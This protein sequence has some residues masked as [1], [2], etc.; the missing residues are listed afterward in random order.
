MAMAPVV[1]ELQSPVVGDATGA[2]FDDNFV[3][4][5]AWDLDS[6]VSDAETADADIRW[7]YIVGDFAGLAAPPLSRYSLNNVDPQ[8]D[9]SAAEAIE[10]PA[11]LR[12]D[13]QVLGGEV[14]DDTNARTV[15]IR[16]RILSPIGGPNDDPVTLGIVASE[17]V[18]LFASDGSTVTWATT[19]IFT[20]NNGPDRF[21]GGV[22]VEETL[23]GS[24]WTTTDFVYSDFDPTQPGNT[25]YAQ[26]ATT[27]ACITVAAAG[28]NIGSLDSPADRFS[29]ADLM[30]YR[31]RMEMSTTAVAG[32]TPLISMTYNS[33]NNEFG[34]EIIV[35]DNVGSAN[36]P[37]NGTTGRG[38]FQFWIT[39]PGLEVAAWRSQVD[40]AY[41][42]ANSAA[43]NFKLVLRL[44]DVA[45]VVNGANRVGTV[46][47]KT[48]ELGR[49]PLSQLIAGETNVYT[50][51]LVA[52]DGATGFE[53]TNI[54]GIDQWAVTFAS[55]V[56]TITADQTPTVGVALS[57]FRPGNG[58]GSAGTPAG[59]PDDYPV[60]WD[61][62]N[63]LLHIAYSIAATNAASAAD[64][65]EVMRLG[66]DTPT[67]EIITNHFVSILG[68]G[69][70]LMPT[71]T[72]AT[73]HAF[74]FTHSLTAAV[75][76]NAGTIRPLLDFADRN[77]GGEFGTD[78]TVT[79]T[80]SFA[81]SEVTVGDV[82]P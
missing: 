22:S 74:H 36:M 34:G 50:G 7:S 28:D 23:D 17:T 13:N 16:D 38:E 44:L 46:C 77:A 19:I 52:A 56:A 37:T 10:P 43:L 18:T 47:W 58:D 21:S 2:T 67:Q 25:T 68:I 57:T 3:F 45:A 31:G 29:I 4:P 49:V 60:A 26:N 1:Q 41:A 55:G 15:T 40:G 59:L 14:D 8:V 39:P 48:V 66:A 5:D 61:T 65:P 42:P 54:P 73:Y 32:Q 75:F 62:P 53:I 51:N 69:E 12:I 35:L 76:A 6:L 24:V 33:P 11:A 81:V 72:A 80:G 30:V 64:P 71:T 78:G 9:P 82:T 27:G 20:D 79:S 70:K 63:Q